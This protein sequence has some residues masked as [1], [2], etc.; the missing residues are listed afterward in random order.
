MH[1]CCYCV[2]TPAGSNPEYAFLTSG[3][4]DHDFFRWALFATGCG[5]PLDQAPPQG[6]AP[7]PAPQQ[8]AAAPAVQQ[9]PQYMPPQQQYY[10]A[11]PQQP[12]AGQ[13]Y[14][15]H[16]MQY[17]QPHA[18]QPPQQPPRP[19]PPPIA[20]EVAAGFSQVL[21]NLSGSKV[22]GF[23]QLGWSGGVLADSMIALHCGTVLHKGPPGTCLW[24]VSKEV[25]TDGRGVG[26]VTSCA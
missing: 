26:H 2:S 11:P 10:S 23:M 21:D 18:V 3:G 6:F 20:P 8:P 15:Q 7:P 9:P 22:R 1:V 16:P 24:F 12:Y 25:G 14:P 4:S 13:P 19:A 17:Q 5:I